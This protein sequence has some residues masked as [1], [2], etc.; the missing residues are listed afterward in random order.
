M[1]VMSR[2]GFGMHVPNLDAAVAFWNILGAD[3]EVED[4]CDG[5]GPYAWGGLGRGLISI[6]ET[7]DP[8]KWT[9]NLEICRELPCVISTMAALEAHGY[10]TILTVGGTLST[11]S[12]CGG[13]KV[14]VVE[15]R[16]VQR[17]RREWEPG[18]GES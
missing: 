16:R 4:E 15:V 10:P 13:V 3:L 11:A 1:S 2:D 8:A 18:F 9:K 17:E 14:I 7:S 12:P 6:Q 5:Q